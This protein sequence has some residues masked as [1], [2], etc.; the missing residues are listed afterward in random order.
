M[1]F[2]PTLT[3]AIPQQLELKIQLSSILEP[4]VLAARMEKWLQTMLLQENH[5]AYFG[6]GTD[7]PTEENK[8]E[9][10]THTFPAV[11]CK[12]TW[13]SQRDWSQERAKDLGADNDFEPELP[14]EEN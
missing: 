13:Q 12:T 8:E 10:K 11:S 3:S 7:F 1:P 4:S 6:L 9:L 2:Q 14:T 5:R